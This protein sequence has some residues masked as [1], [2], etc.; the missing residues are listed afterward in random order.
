MEL[1]IKARS[2][3]SL[4]SDGWMSLMEAMMVFI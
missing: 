2:D 4:V 3:W 1:F